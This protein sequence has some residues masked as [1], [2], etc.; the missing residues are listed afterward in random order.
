M[1][2]QV[3]LTG[4][5]ETS[6]HFILFSFLLFLYKRERERKKRV[7]TSTFHD[8]LFRLNSL[9]KGGKERIILE[10]KK[11]KREGS[12]TGER[13]KRERERKLRKEDEKVSD[14]L[15]SQFSVGL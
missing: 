1:K 4:W 7:V 8:T 5:L 9:K 12:E 6:G 11:K 15:L 10:R 14:F 3:S 13:I 2:L